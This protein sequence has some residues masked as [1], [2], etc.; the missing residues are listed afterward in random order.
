[1][2]TKRPCRRIHNPSSWA[3]VLSFLVFF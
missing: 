2:T 1:M 3:R